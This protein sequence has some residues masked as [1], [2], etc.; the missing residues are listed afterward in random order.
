MRGCATRGGGCCSCSAGGRRSSGRWGLPGGFCEWGE[1]TE[2]CCARE[3]L[4][5]TGLRVEVGALLGVYSRPDRDPRGHNVTVLYDCRPIARRGRRAATTRPRRGGSRRRSSR[6]SR[7]PSTT[8]TIVREQLST[9]FSTAGGGSFSARAARRRSRISIS[10]AASNL[11]LCA[12]MIVTASSIEGDRRTRSRSS[13]LTSLRGHHVPPHPVDEPV[14]HLADQDDR[15]LRHEA[16]LQ[17]LPDHQELERRADAAREEHEG[18]RHAHE[19]VQAREE[20]AV[21]RDAVEVGV[22]LLV[23]ESRS[24]GRRTC[25]F[26]RAARARRPLVGG[27]H[28]A[29]ASARHDVAA[30]LRQARGHLPDVAGTPGPRPSA[31]R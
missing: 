18:L 31:A 6:V 7:S 20:R 11:T 30:D 1:T 12:S 8:A 29:G 10:R 15:P 5:E 24:S 21:G 22:R 25:V 2:A 4:E 14:P 28:E 9:P 27:L 3:T 16:D 19:V 13:A 17:E 26:L 23:R